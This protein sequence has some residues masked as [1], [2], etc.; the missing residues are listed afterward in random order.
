MS[1]PQDEQTFFINLNLIN[2]Q[3]FA[4]QV[5]HVAECPMITTEPM[6]VL[7]PSLPCCRSVGDHQCNVTFLQNPQKEAKASVIHRFP[8]KVA[9]KEKDS[10]EPIDSSDCVNDGESRPTQ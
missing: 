9:R 1:I 2:E 5:V 3:C 8:V 6:V 7:F 10:I 4:T